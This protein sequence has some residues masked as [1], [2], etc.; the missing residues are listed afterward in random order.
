MS[1][2]DLKDI[3]IKNGSHRARMSSSLTI[4]KEKYNKCTLNDLLNSLL[5]LIFYNG[6]FNLYH[7][8]AIVCGDWTIVVRYIEP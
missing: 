2:R 8:N 3:G 1:E 7:G 6:N 4:L 5:N